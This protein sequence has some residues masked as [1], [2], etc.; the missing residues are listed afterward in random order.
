MY[1][2]AAAVDEVS[3]TDAPWSNQGVEFYKLNFPASNIES[4]ISTLRATMEPSRAPASMLQDELA[5]ALKF[6]IKATETGIRQEKSM[7]PYAS[8]SGLM[9]LDEDLQSIPLNDFLLGGASWTARARFSCLRPDAT[10]SS[11]F[12][13]AVR[14]ED[15]NDARTIMDL[16]LH[17]GTVAVFH[18]LQSFQQFAKVNSADDTTFKAWLERNPQAYEAV[19]EAFRRSPESVAGMSYYSWTPMELQAKDGSGHLIKFRLVRMSFVRSAAAFAPPLTQ[20][21]ASLSCCLSHID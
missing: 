16:T 8:A 14:L 2:F 11:I 21:L 15:P 1:M 13:L 12:A 18:S 6:A 9:I 10:Q 20:L 17:T 19:C 4:R 3:A 5:T 7:K